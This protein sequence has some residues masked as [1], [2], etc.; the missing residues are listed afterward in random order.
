MN[1]I[2][3]RIDEI[4]VVETGMESMISVKELERT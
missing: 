1:R 3:E 2:L 4:L